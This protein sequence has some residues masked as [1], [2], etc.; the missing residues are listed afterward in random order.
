MKLPNPNRDDSEPGCH[1]A[2]IVPGKVLK[3]RFFGPFY[4]LNSRNPRS[5]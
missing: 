5:V 2:A 3:L 4:Q 1:G